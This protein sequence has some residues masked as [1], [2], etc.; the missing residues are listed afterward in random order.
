MSEIG[1]LRYIRANGIRKFL[2]KEIRAWITARGVFV[3]TTKSA[4][5][6]PDN[7]HSVWN[8]LLKPVEM[9]GWACILYTVF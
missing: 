1:S 3:C 5:N 4:I 9:V 8:C 7:W 2:A 6:P